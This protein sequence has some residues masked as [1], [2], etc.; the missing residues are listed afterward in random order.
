MS[1]GWPGPALVGCWP[2]DSDL[3]PRDRPPS[4]RDGNGKAVTGF[5]GGAADEFT[6]KARLPPRGRAGRSRAAPTPAKG[7][8]AGP[9]SM[10]SRVRSCRWSPRFRP[11]RGPR[12]PPSGVGP[13]RGRDR[14][15]PGSRGGHRP[16]S[17]AKGL[18]AWTWFYFP[19]ADVA[20]GRARPVIGCRVTSESAGPSLG[21]SRAE[22]IGAF[23]GRASWSRGARGRPARGPRRA[24]R[25]P[26]G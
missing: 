6:A 14:L 24:R 10:P 9:V 12:C 8:R 26:G 17:E 5:A 7:R 2:H 1:C 16:R 4:D 3:C 22:P 21:R 18:T 11:A 20:N 15:G 23:R 19:P 25:R 13:D